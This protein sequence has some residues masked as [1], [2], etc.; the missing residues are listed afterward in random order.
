MVVVP[1]D[2]DHPCEHCGFTYL[3]AERTNRTMC[4]GSGL[5]LSTDDFPCLQPLPTSLKN[6]YR[7]YVT[8]LSAESYRLN[9]CF[10]IS[11]IATDPSRSQGGQGWNYGD[12]YHHRNSSSSVTLHGRL[13]HVIRDAANF[14]PLRWMIHVAS[15]GTSEEQDEHAAQLRLRPETIA[16][17]R[18]AL[19]LYNPYYTVLRVLAPQDQQTTDVRGSNDDAAQ[20]TAR[21]AL[22]VRIAGACDAHEVAAIHTYGARAGVGQWSRSTER[23][24]V[25][26]RQGPQGYTT[27]TISA[28]SCLYEPLCYPLFFCCGED[29]WGTDFRSGNGRRLSLQVY[30]RLR[31]LMPEIGLTTRS[32]SSSGSIITVNRFQLLGKLMQVY[33]VDMWSRVID[34]R[35]DWIRRNQSRFL[36]YES[37]LEERHRGTQVYTATQRNNGNGPQLIQMPDDEVGVLLDDDTDN[38]L[39]HEEEEEQGRTTDESFDRPV[40][41]PSSFTGG[42]RH[43]RKICA[44][45]LTLWKKKG[46]PTLFITATANPNWP[47]I[48]QGVCEGQTAYDRPDITCRV[49]HT[50]VSLL[51]EAI[52]N[53]AI[54]GRQHIV[55]YE[56]RV[57]EYQKRGLPHCHIVLRLEN[58]PDLR[59]S[60]DALVAWINSNICAEIPWVTVTPVDGLLSAQADRQVRNRL[61]RG[62]PTDTTHKWST[63]ESYQ[64][65]TH[66]DAML[67]AY[68]AACKM[69]HRCTTGMATSCRGRVPNTINN[70]AVST[71]YNNT[72]IDI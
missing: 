1:Y 57:I 2:E 11:A 25:I 31:I 7:N 33:V 18:Q 62:H 72:P 12:Q 67:A 48:M 49:F 71:S 13:Y 65:M 66:E 39:R 22:G 20:Q 21:A 45:A 16:T 60:E 5:A 36:T 27:D 54:F 35:L 24:V 63:Y 9:N 70:T 26:W 8:T 23:S 41:L 43:R 56:L 28:M 19:L 6:L 52:R 37:Q 50:K 53:G 10:Q 29:G 59:T 69:I 15:N 32:R 55:I 51:L 42:P 4:C 46:Q 68:I 34:Q 64:S 30:T 47:E 3:Q 40:F 17:I 61:C 58:I 14:A 38:V 44:S